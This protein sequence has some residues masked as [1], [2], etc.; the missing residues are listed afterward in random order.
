[1]NE[2]VVKEQ[3][4]VNHSSHFGTIVE[5][6]DLIGGKYRLLKHLGFPSGQA[7]IY[8]CEFQ[9]V[10]YIA[11]LFKLSM[12]FNTSVL[13]IIR[14][15]K[16][17]LIVTVIEE[18]L[19]KNRRYEIY[20]YFTKGDL[21]RVKK[22][23]E[24]ILRD[25]VIPFINEALKD[26][27]KHDIA[28][29]DLKP[30]NIFVDA[31]DNL[32]LGDFGICSVLADE[33]IKVTSAK[34]TLGYRPPESYSEISIKSKQ[35]DYYGFGMSIIH[36]WTGKNP[37]QGLSEMQIMAHTLDG[38]IPI[39]EDLPDDLQMLVV[40]LTAYDKRS[41]IG[42]DVV[43]R[44]CDGEDIGDCI[45][46]VVIRTRGPFSRENGNY[47]LLGEQITQLE[48]FITAATHTEKH[49]NEAKERLKMGLLDSMFSAFGD[50]AFAVMSHTKKLACSD[51]AL[52]ELVHKT[53]PT[54][55]IGWKSSLFH[56]KA[57]FGNLILKDLPIINEVVHDMN[58]SGFLERLIKYSDDDVASNL[59]KQGKI[60]RL[61]YHL[62]EEAP[63]N[64]EGCVLLSFD[65]LVE[66]LSGKRGNVLIEMDRLMKDD[67]F[68]AWIDALKQ[69]KRFAQM[70]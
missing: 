17:D 8:L 66:H 56:S 51:L 41:R 2:T 27:H 58:D 65:A 9:G 39:P 55:K 21:S 13:N 6:G 47:E 15:I 53:N 37:Y 22:I 54:G 67:Y 3:S 26:V 43:K 24:E 33:S 60:D 12:V 20:P 44:W 50:D 48:D 68:L 25:D 38:K 10:E 62:A 52:A 40:G 49:W 29:M 35:F 30:S 31:S 5:S 61:G 57:A 16:S 7:D 45:S 63:F 59:F 34:G 18:G 42:Y 46:T 36:L 23:D 32:Y 64:Y 11:K 14:N 69:N 70:I 4:Y 19:F 1:M 28:H